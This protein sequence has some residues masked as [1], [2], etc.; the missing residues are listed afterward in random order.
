MQEEPGH[1]QLFVSFWLTAATFG[2]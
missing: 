1:N 2:I